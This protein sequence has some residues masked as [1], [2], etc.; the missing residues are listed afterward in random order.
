MIVRTA[1]TFIHLHDVNSIIYDYLLVFL[2][3]YLFIYFYFFAEVAQSVQRCLIDI[4]NAA[5]T[6]ANGG[7]RLIYVLPNTHIRCVCY[8]DDGHRR[9][10]GKKWFLPNG[11]V[12]TNKN[13]GQMTTPYSIHKA[14][15]SFVVIPVANSSY[16]GIYTCGVGRD[17]SSTVYAT[18]VEIVAVTKPGTYTMYVV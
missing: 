16:N 5:F 13:F 14:Y 10:M 15:S 4:K 7:T 18:T 9:Y 6:T 8:N 2:K 12:V 1:D 11:Q 17:L 3:I